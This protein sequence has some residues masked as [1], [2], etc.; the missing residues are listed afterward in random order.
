MGQLYRL[1]PKLRNIIPYFF[2]AMPPPAQFQFW[3]QLACWATSIILIAGQPHFFALVPYFA[4]LTD[5]KCLF[6]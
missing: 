2:I 6:P 5:G 3:M 1:L 4:P